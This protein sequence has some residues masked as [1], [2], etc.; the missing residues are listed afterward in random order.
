V[1]VCR[2]PA[3]LPNLLRLSAQVTHRS[4]ALLRL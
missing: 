1:G 2:I 3:T 4:A